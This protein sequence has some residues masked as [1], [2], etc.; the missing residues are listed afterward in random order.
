MEW[1]SPDPV[2]LAKGTVGLIFTVW[3]KW[4]HPLFL[5]SFF[6][7]YICPATP[8]THPAIRHLFISHYL[9]IHLIYLF[10]YHS[11]IHPSLKRPL[12]PLSVLIYCVLIVYTNMYIWPLICRVN[13]SAHKQRMSGASFVSQGL[14]RKEKSVCRKLYCSADGAKFI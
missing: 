4:L 13:Q 7:L 10:I 12:I 9:I 8:F 1:Y 3:S 11:F 2:R 5:C 14:R 6:L